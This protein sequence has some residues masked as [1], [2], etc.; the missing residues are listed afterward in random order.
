M[1]LR[2]WLQW[3]S[4]TLLG[5]PLHTALSCPQAQDAVRILAVSFVG[6]LTVSKPGRCG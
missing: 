4:D 1:R 5:S 6:A 2:H 3:Q